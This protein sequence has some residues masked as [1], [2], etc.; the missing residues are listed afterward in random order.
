[1]NGNCFIQT[2]PFFS[3]QTPEFPSGDPERTAGGDL[4]PAA[5]GG[6]TYQC[7]AD[8]LTGLEVRVF[9][10]VICRFKGLVTNY[11]GGGGLKN[12]KGGIGSLTPT[13]RRSEKSFSHAEG[14]AQQVL[15]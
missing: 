3:F 4:Q 13:K 9:S 15:R 5:R 7:R 8:L 1:M 12:R 10:H 6:P 11:R 14:G 2:K